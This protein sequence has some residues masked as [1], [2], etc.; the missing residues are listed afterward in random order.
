MSH[1]IMSIYF[2]MSSFST[3]L[4]LNPL[5]LIVFNTLV[6]HLLFI[7]YIQH[8]FI[9]VNVNKGN[10]YVY[11]SWFTSIHLRFP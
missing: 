11:I 3:L 7:V 2:Q 10:L 6:F 1:Q 8:V 5:L 4:F 9:H